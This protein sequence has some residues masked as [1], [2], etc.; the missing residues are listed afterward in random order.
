MSNPNEMSGGKPAFL[1]PS[2][3]NLRIDFVTE[4]PSITTDH[5]TQKISRVRMA[6]LSPLFLREK[7]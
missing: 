7:A 1:T 3:S 2:L 4:R 5:S 6:G